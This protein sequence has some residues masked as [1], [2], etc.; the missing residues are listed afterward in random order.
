MYAPTAPAW[1]FL[2]PEIPAE[3][4]K[5]P[6]PSLCN[7]SSLVVAQIESKETESGTLPS[8]ENRVQTTDSEREQNERSSGKEDTAGAK[9]L[10]PFK[11]SEE[12]AAEQAVDYPV[13]I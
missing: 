6:R 11:P 13:D 10:K 9:P 1:I 4:T 5:A 2:A 7:W 12:I 3:Q 8:D